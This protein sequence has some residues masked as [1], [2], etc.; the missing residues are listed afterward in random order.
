MTTP[1]V[2][3]GAGGFGRETIDIIEAINQDYACPKFDLLGVVDDKPAQHNVER[4]QARGIRHLGPIREWIESGE[5][6]HYVIAIGS[7]ALRRRIAAPF[8]EAGKIAATVAHPL[9]T[10]GSSVSVGRG[11]IICAGVRVTTNVS[12]G[13][14][15]HVNLNTT[16]GHDCV[17]GDF[18]TVNPS[19]AISGDCT[20]GAEV[21]LGVSSVVLQGLTVGAGSTVG[22]SACVVK[23]V[24]PDV[25][26]KG[27]PAR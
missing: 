19:V 27:V 16:I 21:M 23:N 15:V 24:A 11:S 3:V 12:I 20:I 7:S 8:D 10:F 4:L 1:I 2:V 18:V 14:F 6:A 9:A 5:S 25:V 13:S 26:V 17:I 22:A